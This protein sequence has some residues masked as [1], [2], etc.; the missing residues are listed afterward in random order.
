MLAVKAR[1]DGKQIILPA[2]FHARSPSDVIVVFENGQEGADDLMLRAQEQAFA[3][4]WDNDEDEI[5]DRL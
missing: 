3:K 2:E 4:A 1:Y 5:Y